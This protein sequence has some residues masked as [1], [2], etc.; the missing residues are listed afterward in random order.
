MRGH[1]RQAGLLDVPRPHVLGALEMAVSAFGRKE[2]IA[3]VLLVDACQESHGCGADRADGFPG[4]ATVEFQETLFEVHLWPGQAGNLV[5]TAAREGP[6]AGNIQRLWID[7][8]PLEFIEG[9]AETCDLLE[10]EEALFLVVCLP[11]GSGFARVAGHQLASSRKAENSR[12]VAH[13]LARSAL[14]AADDEALS[15]PDL[16]VASG[17]APRSHHAQNV[18]YRRN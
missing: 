12:K 14:T 1:P 15:W 2:E 9:R 17:L 8:F 6:E 16:F 18:R 5:P 7:A 11:H 10:R 13:D 3:A 4:L